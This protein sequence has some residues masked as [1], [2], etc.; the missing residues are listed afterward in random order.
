MDADDAL[1][2]RE[3][4]LPLPLVRLRTDKGDL[5]LQVMVYPVHGL[6]VGLRLTELLIL[7]VQQTV[8]GFQLIAHMDFTPLLI[9]GI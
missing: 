2:L 1:Q 6:I 8:H 5:V 7:P 3:K 9:M 4:R